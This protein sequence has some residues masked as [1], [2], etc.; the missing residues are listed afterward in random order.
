MN[1]PR[2]T[3]EFGQFAAVNDVRVERVSGDITVLLRADRVPFSKRNAAVV[4]PRGD[5]NRTAF[6]LSAENVVWKRIVS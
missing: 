4:A 6:L 3:V 5:A 1:L 2:S